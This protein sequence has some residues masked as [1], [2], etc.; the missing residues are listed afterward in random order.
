M[1]SAT[2]RD[3][4]FIEPVNTCLLE[5]FISQL[6]HVRR[7][8]SRRNVVNRFFITINCYLRLHKSN[9][10]IQIKVLIIYPD[11]QCT[12]LVL[13]PTLLH[14]EMMVL[15]PNTVIMIFEC[16]IATT[17]YFFQNLRNV[18][19]RKD[20]QCYRLPVAPFHWPCNFYE[21]SKPKQY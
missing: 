21:L 1:K 14:F 8:L 15:V 5:P 16:I 7:I 13:L 4:L 2:G 10:R 20:E 17:Y 12:N 11:F 6:H 18:E 19:G 3:T 9:G